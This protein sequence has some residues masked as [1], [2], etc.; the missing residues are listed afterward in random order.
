MSKVHAVYTSGPIGSRM[1]RTAFAMLAGTLSMSGYNL[2]DTYFIGRLEGSAPLAAMG[3]S[4]PV[5]MLIGCIFH[6]LGNGIMAI[7]AQAL[8]SRRKER[9]A[10]FVSAGLLLV[11]M[12][13]VVLAVIGMATCR[14]LF[15]FFGATGEALY[16]VQTYMD[17]W[18]F[19]CFSGALAMAGNSLLIGVGD[20]KAASFSMMGGMIINVVLD[21]LFIFG[22]WI[23]PAMG[24]RGAVLATIGS[25]FCV[26]LYNLGRLIRKH[27]LLRFDPI[28]LKRLFPCWGMTMRYGI[29]AML[30][31]L[32]MPLASVVITKVT[33]TFGDAA[34]AATAAAG[35]LEMVAF[36]FPMALGMTLVPMI[37]QN[38]GAK[39][40]DRIRDCHRFSMRF[41]FWYLLILGIL[42]VLFAPQL[43][44]LFSRDAEVCRIMA[45]CMR[46]I[47]LG[48]FAIEIHRY[49]TFF[50]TG[51]GRPNAAAWLNA[52]RIL[53]L[54]IPLTLL[55]LVFNRLWLVFAARLAADLISGT[56]SYLLSKRLILHKIGREQQK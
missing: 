28:P 36:V 30:G 24:I 27:H 18:F 26:M 42:Y 29:P 6:G 15:L 49:G 33:A 14:K 53:G 52:L 46:I 21:P 45:E 55:A 19:G 2:A 38:Y 43:V 1:I 44:R 50:Y 25:Q 20:N 22:W 32:M 23:F 17:I 4:L 47:P 13:S 5:I 51:C 11:A 56:I 40:Y 37:G 48:F 31:M 8:G 16:H 34:V 7:T 9:A 12:F 39:L 35:R 10:A 41:A 54:M 3:F